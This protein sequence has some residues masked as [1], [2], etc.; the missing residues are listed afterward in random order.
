MLSDQQFESIGDITDRDKQNSALLQVLGDID[1][2]DIDKVVSALNA[3]C[4]S[5]LVT[6]IINNGRTFSIIYIP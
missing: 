6:Y 4:Q 5:H 2:S 1:M 3:T